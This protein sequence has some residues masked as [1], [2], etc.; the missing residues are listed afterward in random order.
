[1]PKQVTNVLP[2]LAT[3]S[4]LMLGV[5]AI[6]VLGEDKLLLA[7]L[8]IALGSILDVVDGQLAARFGAISDIGKELDS[9]ADVVTFGVAPSI[10]VYRLLLIVH[11]ATPVAI[12][13]SLVYVIA[14]AF[15]LARYNTMPSDRSAYYKGMPIPMASALVITGSFWQHWVVDLWSTV[16]VIAVSC[17]M[18]SSFR[19]PNIKHLAGLPPIAWAGVATVA[20]LSWLAGGWQAIPFGLASLYALSG[21]ALWLHASTQRRPRS[22]QAVFSAF[23]AA[24]REARVA[25]LSAGG[26]LLLALWLQSPWV[27]LLSAVLLGSVVYFFRNPER[28]PDSP[29][30]EA[31][32]A[33]ADGRVTAI[34]TVEEPRFSQGPSWRISIFLSL[35]DVHV[36]RSPCAGVVQSM[37]YQPGAFAPAFLKDTHLNESNLIVLETSHGRVAVKQIAGRLARRI[38]CWSGMGDSLVAGQRLGLIKFGSRVDLLLPPGVEVMGQ[39]GQHVHGGQTVVAQW[40][41]SD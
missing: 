23:S 16:V 2:S 24:W 22:S 13:I 8:L 35:F 11:V 5:L 28:V 26:V 27:A 4:S 14:G 29:S 20:L 15:R 17:L 39:V 10:L 7:A 41:V 33:P 40:I 32:L 1:M 36:Q 18:A 6:M 37:C 19:Y 30:S 38:V 34:E 3:I 25:V 31:I 12:A 9:L 21:P